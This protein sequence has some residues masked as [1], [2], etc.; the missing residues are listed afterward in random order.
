MKFAKGSFGLFAVCE[1]RQDYLIVNHTRN[2]KGYVN[3]KN[4]SDN[5]QFEVGQFLVAQVLSEGGTN[6]YDGAEGTRNKKL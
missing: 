1:V 3:I 5:S 4:M 6:S 2:T